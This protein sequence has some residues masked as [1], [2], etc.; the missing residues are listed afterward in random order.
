M[1]FCWQCDDVLCSV[2]QRT[3]HVFSLSQ[4]W[5]RKSAGKPQI[6][7]LERIADVSCRCFFQ[8]I[9]WHFF[10]VKNLVIYPWKKCYSSQT[11]LRGT[12]PWDWPR[13]LLHLNTGEMVLNSKFQFVN[14]FYGFDWVKYNVWRKNG[15]G[16]MR[17][18]VPKSCIIH[19]RS[20]IGSSEQSDLALLRLLALLAKAVVEC[21]GHVLFEIWSWF[22][23][24]KDCKWLKWRFILCTKFLVRWFSVT[25]KMWLEN[26]CSLHH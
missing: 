18:A 26:G 22:C 13:I 2:K 5:T 12:A 17:Y 20:P 19:K 10:F 16:R 3:P 7:R 23:C 9:Q 21:Q 15:I 4:N 8:T 1:L 25:L 11:A 14:Y 24:C 6:W